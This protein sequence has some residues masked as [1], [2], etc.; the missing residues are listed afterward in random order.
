MMKK[1]S[2]GITM[3]AFG[4]GFDFTVSNFKNGHFLNEMS[5]S[6]QPTEVDFDYI[7]RVFG[8]DRM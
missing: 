5:L 8:Y 4:A 1:Y 2:N 7:Y 3:S 6:S